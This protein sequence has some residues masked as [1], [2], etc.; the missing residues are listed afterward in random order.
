MQQQLFDTPTYDALVA[1]NKAIVDSLDTEVVATVAT[2][3][4]G[5]RIEMI[6]AFLKNVRLLP[7]E[8]EYFFEVEAAKELAALLDPMEYLGAAG[9]LVDRALLRYEQEKGELCERSC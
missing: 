3:L 1:A 6:V 5:T 4:L 9:C 2:I 7:P 8:F